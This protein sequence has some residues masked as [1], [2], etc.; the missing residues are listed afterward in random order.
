MTLSA[1]RGFVFDLDGT[2]VQRSATGVTPVPGAADVLATVRASGR[3]LVVFTNASH[4][5]PA[6]LAAGV[7]T[8][9][10]QLGDD[11]VLTP[12]CSA[13]SHLARRYAGARVLL[14][15][16]GQVAERMA[17]AGV[18]LVPE[19]EAASAEVVLVAHVD[20][21]ELPLLEN[22]A[23][24]VIAGAPLLTASYARA[25]AG[26]DGPILSR[27]A[28]TTAAIA[29]ASGRRPAIVGKPSRAAIREAALR[30][31]VPSEEIAVIGDDVGM[32]IA[33]GHLGGSQTV[34]V[35]SGI[36]GADL[37]GVPAHRRPDH[38]V[39]GVADLLPLL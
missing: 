30:L 9:G 14:L 3:P 16:T 18:E 28:M 29:K 7:R 39:D 37:R 17:A 6:Q 13:L 35:R 36:T 10:L 19:A 22:A 23:R 31:G 24:A 5:G 34:L 11:E 15:G 21:V 4:V 26:A 8:S 32:D 20:R 25:Y 12:I 2:L 27:G 38:V 33:L 1:T